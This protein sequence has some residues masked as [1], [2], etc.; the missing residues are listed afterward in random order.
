MEHF[1]KRGRAII[2]RVSQYEKRLW[3]AVP[4]CDIESARFQ[5]LCREINNLPDLD[6]KGTLQKIIELFELNGFERIAK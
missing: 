4:V 3:F 1:Q 2:V 6:M 5:A